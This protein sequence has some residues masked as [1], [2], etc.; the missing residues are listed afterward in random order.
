MKSTQVGYG[1]LL[2]T[3]LRV[4]AES[5]AAAP[6]VPVSASV[7]VP[8]VEMQVASILKPDHSAEIAEMS[9]LRLPSKSV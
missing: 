7:T 9:P 8:Q 3:R 5:D 2:S 1:E 4:I 6:R